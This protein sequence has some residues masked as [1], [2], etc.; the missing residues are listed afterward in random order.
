MLYEIVCLVIAALGAYGL[1]A[2]LSRCL[3]GADS[4]AVLPTS[5]GIH[6][7]PGFSEEEVEVALLLLR[8][9]G[10]SKDPILLIDCPLREEVLEALEDMGTHLYLSYEE[11]RI[12]KRK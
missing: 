1:Y 6:I 12:E 4:T 7:L 2:L 8:D 9:G 11:Y 5:V 10:R 3:G